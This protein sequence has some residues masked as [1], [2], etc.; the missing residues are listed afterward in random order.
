MMETALYLSSFSNLHIKYS[1]GSSLFYAD[2]MTREFNKVYLDDKNQKL[3]DVWSQ[4]HPP[5]D[6]KHIGVEI[7]PEMLTDLLCGSPQS[8]Y[9]D[10]FAKRKFYDQ[11]LSRYHTSDDSVLRCSDPIPVELD[12]LSSIYGGW[13]KEK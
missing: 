5:L 13:N 8:E 12:F 1:T 2:L 4:L 10:C 11:S 9:I 6:K 7:S 3:S